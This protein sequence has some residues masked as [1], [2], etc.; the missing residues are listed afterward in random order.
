MD[1]GG[2]HK[3]PPPA[4]ELLAGMI[5][6]SEWDFPEVCDPLFL[7]VA[8]LRKE[9]ETAKEDNMG[10]REAWRVSP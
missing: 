7:A 1:G 10:I 6:G 2:A 5:A 9:E 8:Q 3:A 4:E